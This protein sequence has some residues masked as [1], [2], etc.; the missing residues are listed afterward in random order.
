MIE[1]IF[2]SN[3]F[4]HCSSRSDNLQSCSVLIKRN[5]KAVVYP[6]R[7]IRH[8]HGRFSSE[9]M[10]E[11]HEILLQESSS[12]IERWILFWETH[13]CNPSVS[14][15]SIKWSLY[16]KRCVLISFLFA[17]FDCIID[18]KEYRSVF[19]FNVSQFEQW[20]RA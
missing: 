15:C 20:K 10:S 13:T 17:I 7:T 3:Y 16:Y 19:M 6:G 18:L 14:F 1:V 8:G 5:S 12:W 4:Y 9:M 2:Y 11:S